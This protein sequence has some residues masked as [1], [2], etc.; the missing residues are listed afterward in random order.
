[1]LA[2]EAS[3]ATLLGLTG[4]LVV[5]LAGPRGTGVSIMG[6][7]MTP[8][9]CWTLLAVGVAAAV[10]MLHRRIALVFCATV[11][12][13]ALAMVIVSAVAATH[14][15]PGPLGFTATATVLYAVFFCANLAIGMWLVP[16]HIEGQAWLRVKGSP[17]D[18]G[19]KRAD[20]RL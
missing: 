1:M 18:I 2:G 9:L 15:A 10:A 5:Y 6:L 8:A 14:H 16:D 20:R 11:G 19:D 4:L 17:P 13:A 3:A 7:D 12:S